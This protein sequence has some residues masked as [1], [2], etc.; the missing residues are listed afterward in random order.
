VSRSRHGN[1]GSASPQT[2]RG[3]KR[4]LCGLCALATLALAPHAGADARTGRLDP[5]FGDRGRAVT[6]LDFG[7]PRYWYDVRVHLALAPA[8]QILVAANNL[9]LRY[10]P[11]G[12]IDRTFGD[13]GAL[14]L[15]TAEGHP[16]ELS[17]LTVDPDGRIVVA[18]TAATPLEGGGTTSRAAVL[19]L[20]ANGAP[21]PTF[22][23]GDGASVTD[24]G[25]SAVPHNSGDCGSMCP[26]LSVTGASVDP[27]GRIVV[28]G[29]VLR[30]TSYCGEFVGFVGRLDTQGNVDPSFGSAGAV[31]SEPS[32]MHSADGLALDASGGPLFFGWDGYC[33]GGGLSP[34]LLQR[35]EA[36]GQ[37]DPAFGQGGE[38]TLAPEPQ[39]IDSFPL[40]IGLD[41]SGRIAILRGK[42]VQRLLPSGEA[43]PS[44]GHNGVAAIPLRGMRS[45]FGDLAS[46][47]RGGFALAGTRVHYFRGRPEPRRRLVLALLGPRG[48]LDRHFGDAGVAGARFGLP[49][50]AVGRQVVLDGRGHALAAGTV[51]NRRLPTG[52]GVALY[53]FDL[54]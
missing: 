12:R 47:P 17:A 2:G 8:G 49:F 16:F 25:L 34:V 44:F 14:P 15:K 20:D 27:N 13:N 10:L 37:P 38:L 11:S 9:L 50:N 32:A 54:R 43:D 52:E 6:A 4:A 24:L 42:S 51:R 45:Q 33:H 23:G 40:Q 3:I 26:S 7:N 18:G 48:R 5:T 19:R 28:A 36:N 1:R 21:D 39:A 53:R 30:A 35:L 22:G 41:D 31:V 29:S 46:T